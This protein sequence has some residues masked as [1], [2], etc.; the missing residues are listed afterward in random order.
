MKIAYIILTCKQNID[1]RVKYQKQTFLQTRDIKIG[2]VNC[3]IDYFCI[4]SKMEEPNSSIYGWNTSD[5][6]QD[7]TYKYLAFIINMEIPQY[8]WYFF[9]DDDT[10]VFP[11]RLVEYL[12]N[13]NSNNRFY[14]GNT[15]SITNHKL[16]TFDPI[17]YMSGGSGF[18]LSKSVYSS[19][20]TYLTLSENIDKDPLFEIADVTMGIW[21]NRLSQDSPIDIID[22][23]LF[24]PVKHA[25]A[26]EL[27]T[28][29]TFHNVKIKDEY[30]FYNSILQKYSTTVNQSFMLSNT[31]HTKNTHRLSKIAF[32]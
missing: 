1:L 14:I 15:Y 24:N 9:I 6:Y 19:L 32:F 29:I 17:S 27:N 22:C 2:L 3:N 12:A 5:K 31:R 25:N 7:L 21:I 20:K 16:L 4:S 18:L 10:F 30:L 13:Y 28:N 26:E 11:N 23:K 8:D